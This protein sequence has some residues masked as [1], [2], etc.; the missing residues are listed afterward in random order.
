MFSKPKYGWSKFDYYGFQANA[1]YLIDIPQEWLIILV[2]HGRLPIACRNFVLPIDE[3]GQETYIIWNG[4]TM[5]V[6]KVAE[7]ITASELKV[8][9]ATFILDFCNDIE[10]DIDDWVNFAPIDLTQEEFSSRKE[11]IL[12]KI[13]DLRLQVK[14]NTW[15]LDKDVVIYV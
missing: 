14:R 9:L 15:L 12:I 11:S 5:S 7:E 4:R 10:R 1:S 3:E 13:E 8:D 6:M 2:S